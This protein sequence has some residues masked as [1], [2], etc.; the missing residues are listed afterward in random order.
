MKYKPENMELKEFL[1]K[2]LTY[3]KSNKFKFDKISPNDNRFRNYFNYN[4]V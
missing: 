3:D 1:A 4:T 2:C